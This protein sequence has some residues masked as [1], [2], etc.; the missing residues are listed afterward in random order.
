M[1]NIILVLC[2]ALFVGCEKEVASVEGTPG[3]NGQD[4]ESCVV[5]GKTISCG[6]ETS[7][8]LK[9][10]QDGAAGAQGIQGLKGDK[11]N[12]GDKGEKGD[13]GATGA[14]G[15]QGVAGAKGA[16]GAQG[17]KG[18]DGATLTSGAGSPDDNDG[19]DGD[20][21]LD[22]STNDLFKKIGGT[23]IYQ[24]NFTGAKGDN[25]L[26]GKDG[27]NGINGL[28]GINGQDGKDGLNGLNGVDGS[29]GKN[30]LNGQNGA[31]GLNGKDGED[32][33]DCKIVDSADGAK[34]TC[35]GATVEVEDGKDGADGQDGT[36]GLNGKDGK[37]GLNGKD[38]TD[39]VVLST[40]LAP[41]TGKCYN[42]AP[43]IWVENEGDHADVYNNNQCSHLGK[44]EKYN[45]AGAICNDIE[46]Y[47]KFD[48]SSGEICW[49]GDLQVS[50][51]GIYGDMVIK[52]L[53]F[54]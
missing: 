7:V 14:Q 30:G 53:N 38:G 42:V 15:T 46:P 23:Y 22:T 47:G 32:G 12:K 20:F 9:D 18:L 52:V 16:T 36:N 34:I 27:V 50:I 1:R 8:T 13:K 54:N 25:G 6:E 29:D 37:D 17:I 10:G 43:G 4:G 44:A 3:Q 26:D 33:D 48:Y 39:G 31:D 24:S 11:G 28:A 40:V 45:D 21:Y 2:L 49:V 35:G 5:N 51:E 41:I 19:K